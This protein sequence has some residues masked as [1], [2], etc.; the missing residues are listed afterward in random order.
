[1]AKTSPVA[2]LEELKAQVAELQSQVK[3]LMAARSQAG[4]GKN[5]LDILPTPFTE[6]A[7]MAYAIENFTGKAL[8]QVT[9]MSGKIIK[10]LLL[11]QASGQVEL[12]QIPTAAGQLIF[13]IYNNGQLVISRQSVKM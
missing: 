3:A 11:T 12:N 2:D 4:P 6:K 7:K 13:S 9:D 5:Q 1:M 8:L 10:T